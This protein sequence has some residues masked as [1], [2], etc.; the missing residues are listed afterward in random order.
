M[1][2]SGSETLP[3]APILGSLTKYLSISDAEGFF[4]G[5]VQL[6]VIKASGSKNV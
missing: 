1:A 2:W 4:I 3:V 6:R 5:V